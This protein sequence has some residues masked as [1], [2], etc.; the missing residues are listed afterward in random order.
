M[1][2][3]WNSSAGGGRK[4][5]AG[6][7][8]PIHPLGVPW[9]RHRRCRKLLEI[10]PNLADSRQHNAGHTGNP[11][12]STRQTRIGAPAAEHTNTAAPT[13]G[14]AAQHDLRASVKIEVLTGRPG[15]GKTSELIDEMTGVPGRYLFASPAI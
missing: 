11:G 3:P 4:R 15:A 1:R 13:H 5:P 7:R 12:L 6:A 14:R 9:S 10:R 2:L 8:R